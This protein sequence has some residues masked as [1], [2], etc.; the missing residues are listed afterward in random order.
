MSLHLYPEYAE[1]QATMKAK[2]NIHRDKHARF[3]SLFSN[4]ELIWMNNDWFAF[5]LLW[6]IIQIE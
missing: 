1:E 3:I 4:Y 2:P 6:R 5:R